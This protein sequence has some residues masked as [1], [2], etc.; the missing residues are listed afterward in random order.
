MKILAIS[1]RVDER[2]YSEHIHHNYGDVDLFVGC[3]DLPCYYLEY[4]VSM[5]NQPVLYVHGN[6]DV[7]VSHTATG[8][9][10]E[11]AEGCDLIDGRVVNVKGLLFMGLGGSIR[12]TPATPFQ[13]T[14]GQ[15]RARVARLIPRLFVNKLRYGRFVDVVIT[16]APPYGIHDSADRAH[17]GFRV[18]LTLMAWFKPRYL[19]HGHMHDRKYNAQTCTTYRDTKVVGVFPVRSVEI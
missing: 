6:H 15:M 1:D 5:V 12:Y 2:V 3:G 7:E 8:R 13:Y 10:A 4:V 11:F 17:V 18:F 16:H 14:E 9:R 19:L